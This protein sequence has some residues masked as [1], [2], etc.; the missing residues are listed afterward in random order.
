[1]RKTLT[2][3]LCVAALWLAMSAAAEEFEGL[4]AMSLAQGK[5]GP[6]NT[7]WIGATAVTLA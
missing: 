7:Y 2:L 1:M 5:L 3:S 4:D 6:V